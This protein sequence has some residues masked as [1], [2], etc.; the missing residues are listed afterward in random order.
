MGKGKFVSTTENDF[1]FIIR[2]FILYPENSTF[3]K[4]SFVQEKHHAFIVSISFMIHLRVI[5]LFTD[6]S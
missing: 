3:L 2:M 5:A 4:R 1:F 6:E